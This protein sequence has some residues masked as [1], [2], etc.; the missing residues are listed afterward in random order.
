MLEPSK[1]ER[2]PYGIAF[3]PKPFTPLERRQ[4][5]FQSNLFKE[6]EKLGYKVK[7]EAP[8]GLSSESGRN[9]IEFMLRERT[10]RTIINARNESA[11]RVFL[12]SGDVCHRKS[13]ILLAFGLRSVPP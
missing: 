1:R 5:R 6:A 12:N 8:Y 3:Q 7:G 10:I 13:A 11:Q 9:R 2:W 4:L